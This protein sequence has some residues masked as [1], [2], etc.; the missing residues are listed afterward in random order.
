MCISS[1]CFIDFIVKVVLQGGYQVVGD[2]SGQA[3]YIFVPCA[4]QAMLSALPGQ[5]FA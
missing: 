3:M 5:V 1:H 2:P 4:S